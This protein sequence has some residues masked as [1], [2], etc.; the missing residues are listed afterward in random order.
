MKDNDLNIDDAFEQLTSILEQMDSPK[1][2]LEE[3]LK[4]YKQ[5]VGILNQCSTKLSDIE[6]EIIILT[7][8]GEMPDGDTDTCE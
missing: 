5:G 6:K 3:S 4:L 1:V 7:E 8:E 2:S